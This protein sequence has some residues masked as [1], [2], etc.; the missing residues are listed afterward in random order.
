MG[1]R[2]GRPQ[3][4]HGLDEPAPHHSPPETIDDR[5][6]EAGVAGIG[7]PVGQLRASP[8]ADG[9]RSRTPGILGKAGSPSRGL[10]TSPLRQQLHLAAPLQAGEDGSQAVIVVLRPAVEGMVVAVGALEPHA[11]EDPGGVFGLGAGIARDPGEVRRAVAMRVAGRQEERAGHRVERH[12]PADLIAEPV[13][14]GMRPLGVSPAPADPQER[15]EPEGPVLVEVRRPEQS[16]DQA[17][18]S[19]GVRVREELPDLIGSGQAAGQV[20]PGPSQEGRVVDGGEAGRRSV[21]SMARTA[22]SISPRLGSPDRSTARSPIGTISSIGTTRSRKRATSR[23][24]PPR[25]TTARADSPDR[26]D[27]DGVGSV[28]VKTVHRVTSSTDPSSNRAT[29]RRGTSEPPRIDD[30]AGRIDVEARQ[31]ARAGSRGPLGD[32]SP[33]PIRARS[34]GRQGDSPLVADHAGRLGQQEALV[35]PGEV[36]PAAL[37]LV[38]DG[39]VIAGGVA[40]QQRELEPTPADRRAVAC[41]RVAALRGSGP[42]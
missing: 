20:E 13:V 14:E 5:P 16:I 4:V 36:D 17:S 19:L 41:P 23:F 32:P 35:G 26:S 18:P 11:Q 39:L 15:L 6:G 3:V 1:G 12:P 34:P 33:Q 8:S 10:M 29:A 42:G 22:S 30:L 9:S 2:V 38:D 28:G 25:W 27:L 21:A 31:M 24:C 37:Q 7:E 40:P